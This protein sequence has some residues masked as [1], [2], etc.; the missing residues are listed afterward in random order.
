MSE[1]KLQIPKHVAIIMD[2]NGRWAVG[3][4]LNR[5]EGHRAGGKVVKSIVESAVRLDIKYL[6]LFSFSTEN[7]K[8]GE[9]EVATIMGLF[10]EYL[11]NELR[12][13][14]ENGICLKAMGDIEGLPDPVKQSL[15]RNI[16]LSKDNNRLTLVLA[17]NYG[18]REEIVN[19]VVSIANRVLKGELH[20]SEID[21]NLISD[22]LWSAGIPDPDL[23]I[24]TSGELRISNFL[25]WQLAYSEIVV[26]DE[27]WPDFTEEVFLR[28]LSEFS[29]RERRFGLTSDQIARGEHK[30]VAKKLGYTAH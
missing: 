14:L 10:K 26:A 20:P 24:R 27:C 3:Q 30:E 19:S 23:L 12:T 2:G 13:L 7:W 29:K 17:L 11:D 5:A 4:G 16:E 22:S 8:R 9:V 1:N 21:K 15:K 25:L 6:T 28:C 18:G